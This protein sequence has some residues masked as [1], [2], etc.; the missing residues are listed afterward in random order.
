[1]F[2]GVIV[3]PL[4]FV[5][6]CGGG[7]AP[8][9]GKAAD[10]GGFQVPTEV[11][12]TEGGVAEIDKATKDTENAVVLVDFWTI[13]S[14]PSPDLALV[15]FSR[16]GDGQ[17]KGQTLA[18]NRVA[19]HGVRKGQFMGMKY[20]GWFLRVILVNVDGPAKKDEVLKFLKDHDARYVTNILWTGDPAAATERYG[21]TG[22][23]PHQA[24]FARNGKRVW[25]TGEPYPGDPPLK[26]LDDI[27]FQELDK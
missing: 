1:L 3:A 7:R 10:R 15:G 22:K 17:A 25:I 5:V 14:E 11:V 21:F 20:E 19:W 23:A 6:G 4:V 16:T 8:A 27:I 2:S 26:S 13:A 24:I 18:N 12:L 9:G